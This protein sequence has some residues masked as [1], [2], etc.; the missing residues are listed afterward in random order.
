MVF[1]VQIPVSQLNQTKKNTEIQWSDVNTNL[2]NIQSNLPNVIKEDDTA[3]NEL[4]LQEQI[5]ES[6]GKKINYTNNN[7]KVFMNN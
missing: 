5:T 3:V 1:C 7:L 4:L 6:K 2:L